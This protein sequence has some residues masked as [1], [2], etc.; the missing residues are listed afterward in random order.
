MLSAPTPQEDLLSHVH[1][2][3]L[4][5]NGRWVSSDILCFTGSVMMLSA[6]TECCRAQKG[7]GAAV[8]QCW[9]VGLDP[10]RLVYASAMCTATAT[11]GVYGTSVT[12][13][14]CSQVQGVGG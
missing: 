7:G 5:S 3:L 12:V 8:Q 1:A 9:W 11:D 14:M 10:V 6:Q 2:L 13:C 4:H